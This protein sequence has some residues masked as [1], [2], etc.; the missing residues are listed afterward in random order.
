MCEDKVADMLVV[1]KIGDY[2]E[3]MAGLENL[4]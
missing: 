3:L 1:E 4:L 2:N